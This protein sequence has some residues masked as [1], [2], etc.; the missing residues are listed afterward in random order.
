ML[1]L[2]INEERPLQF[3]IDIQGIDHKELTGSLKFVIGEVEYGFP[4]EILSDQISVKVPP[5]NSIVKMG[6]TDGDVIDCRLDIF[7][8]GFHLNPWADQF[9]MKIPV[10]MEAKIM[11]REKEKEKKP[12]KYVTAK[13]KV[14]DEEMSES[15]DELTPEE[16][17]IPEKLPRD[18]YSEIDRDDVVE[19]LMKVLE[20]KKLRVPS[21]KK[22]TS[23]NKSQ[24]KKKI[25]VSKTGKQFLVTEKVAAK[26]SEMLKRQRKSKVKLGNE[27]PIALMESLGMKNKTIQNVMLEKAEAIGGDDKSSQYAALERLLGV[28]DDRSIVKDME[29]IHDSVRLST[30]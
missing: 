21:K 22:S 23:E 28:K 20:K 26:I 10:R 27:D 13:L 2:N 25:V 24:V 9:M 14:G 7:G 5:L 1:K 19:M 29:R 8:N 3:E 6:L 16:D 18:E 17:D 11:E 12:E 4:V 30:K 15:H